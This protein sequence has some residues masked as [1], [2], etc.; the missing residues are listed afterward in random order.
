MKFKFKIQQYQ[1][2]AV[3][4][5]VHV[6]NGQPSKKESLYR[7]DLG[8]RKPG[9]IEYEEEYVGYRNQDV[10]L[11]DIHLLDNIRSIQAVSE[12]SQSKELVRQNGLGVCSLDIEMET[13]TGKTYVY[14]K[15]MFELN[16]LY[17]W[18]KFIVVV[19]SIAIREGVFKSFSMLEEHFM[20]QYGKKSRYFIY[21]S[22]NLQQ[23]DSF[24]ADANINVMIINVQAFNTS[25]KE[26]AKNKD[27]RIIYSKRDDF[28]SRRPIDVIAANRP[29]IIMD[30]P[31]KM[32]GAA[33]Q[34][35][36]KN[37]KPLFVLN[38]SATHKTV[39][40]CIYALD[41]LDAYKKKLVKKIQVKGITLQNLLGSNSYI[42]FDSIILSK[43][44]APVVRLELEVKG[45]LSTRRETHKF[46]QGDSLY[47]ISH[48]SVYKGFVV[49]NINAYNNSITFLSGDTLKKGEVMG[50]V[51]EQ[52]IQRVQIRET[53][54]SHFEKERILF[55]RGIKTL[56]LFFIDEVANYKSYDENN[57]EVH[58]PLWKIFEEEYTRYLNDN[59]SL[60]EDNYQKYLRRDS[61]D[62]VHN[63]YFSIDKKGHAINSS[64]SRGDDTSNDISAYDLILKNKERLLSFDEPTRF[65]F[66]HSALREGWDNP[67]V[68]QICTL[69]H[70][71]SATAKR[72]EVG[73]G[74]RICVDQDG[75][76]MDY[77]RLGDAVHD[78]N[79]LTVVANENYSSFVDA[80]Q[81]ETKE[82]LRER[83]TIAN[84]TYFEGRNINIEG[85]QHVISNQEAVSIVAWL[86]DNDYIDERGNILQS[87]RDDLEAGTFEPMSKKLQPMQEEIKRLVQGIYEPSILEG[88]VEDGN[89]SAEVPNDHLNENAN[90]EEFKRL[91]SEI[92]HHYVYT[93]HYDSDELIK[94]AIE[95]IDKNLTVKILKYVVTIGTQGDE[96]LEFTGNKTTATKQLSE[97]CTSTVK[98]DLVG[99]IARGVTLT[100]RTVVKIL[101]GINPA[102]L[103]CFKN[104]PEEFIR[105]VIKL[106]KEQKAT[107]IVEHISYNKTE[108][109]YDTNI[110]T[111]EKHSQGIERAYPAKKHILDYVFTDGIAKESTEK[112]F[113]EALD[114]AEEVSVY[115]KLPRSFQI[116][117]PVGHYSPDWAIAFKKG[118]VKH[119][120]FIA[121]TKGSLDSME[122]R[123]VEKAKIECAKKLFNDASTSNVKYWNVT[124]YQDLLDVM[125]GIE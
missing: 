1:S 58:G 86:F 118:T 28:Q 54:K 12:I 64:T 13:G 84:T 62:K 24:S 38:Y 98:Y 108:N 72:Q 114:E 30:E 63:G 66:S 4:N 32:E 69:R 27:A 121:E 16:K 99:E 80:L 2:D 9:T 57:E 21:N 79:K 41:A 3:E 125:V 18:S 47:D 40:N 93:V 61:V 76:R 88:M 81:K 55:Q 35:A 68:F 49:N 104:N 50:D 83:P 96:E 82:A 85:E 116:P 15:T 75:N 91:W 67:N 31:Q 42:Y 70:A 22:S 100:R 60:F 37:F 6:F 5:T 117:T 107:M 120:F 87:Y 7:R 45:A 10:E 97:V 36:L 123:G 73:R 105:N 43:N 51:S 39:H 52:T 34:R 103:Y 111:E 113:A 92:N 23:I 53:V 44:H 17:G 65:I 112:K 101:K 89:A 56:S 95:S 11:D 33:T 94:K 8:K 46:E 106:I 20:E 78:I 115:A 14:I 110:F 19:P 59:L 109:T 124:S 26:D 48:L 25:F 122:L 119:I 77:E 90:K 102:R 29:I 71:N 74:L